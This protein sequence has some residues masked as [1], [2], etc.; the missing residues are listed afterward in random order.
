MRLRIILTSSSSEFFLLRKARSPIDK[1]LAYPLRTC[2]RNHEKSSGFCH[3]VLAAYR[4]RSPG[5]IL[6]GDRESTAISYL[7]L[8]YTLQE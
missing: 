7:P 3:P 4:R 6:H 2:F 5:P 8:S 1:F